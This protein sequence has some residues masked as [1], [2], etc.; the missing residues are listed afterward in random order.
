MKYCLVDTYFLNDRAKTYPLA[1]LADDRLF[2]MTPTDS[3]T[4][5][6]LIDSSLEG[7]DNLSDIIELI[8]EKLGFNP[9]RVYRNFYYIIP[10]IKD[11]DEEF[12]NFLSDLGLLAYDYVDD[13]SGYTY[14]TPTTTESDSAG[15]VNLDAS[16]T[17]GLTGY[18]SGCNWDRGALSLAE[19]DA[20]FFTRNHLNIFQ[21]NLNVWPESFISES[22]F[23]PETIPYA[24]GETQGEDWRRYCRI[25]IEVWFDQ[26]LGKFNCEVQLIG[27]DFN[28]YWYKQTLANVDT[29]DKYNPNDPTPG[30][31][32]PNNKGGQPDGIP[33]TP[34]VTIPTL[35][36]GGMTAAGSIRL[37]RMNSTMIKDLFSYLHANDPGTSIV[38]WFQ[39]PSQAIISLHYLPYELDILGATESIKVLGSDTGVAAY[40]AKERQTIHFGYSDFPRLSDNYLAYSPYT[41]VSIYLPGIG[42]RELN[43]DDIVNKRV[44]VV[45]HCDNVTG[46][47]VA[48][49]AV[50]TKTQTESQASVKYTFSGQVAASWPISQTNWGDTYIAGATLAAGALASGVAAAGTAGAAA[51]GE[52]GAAAGT[53][54]NAGA[55]MTAAN[56]AGGAI[57]KKA[58]NIGSSISSLAKPTISRSGTVSGV[59]S[60]MGI[61]KPYFVIETP[62]Q[63]SYEGFAKVKGYPFG[64]AIKLG[65]LKG[66]AIIEDCHLSGIAGTE[67]EIS[68][69]EGLLKS[70]VIL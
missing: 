46:Q 18:L 69:I 64:Q 23:R 37:Y 16:Y 1:V 70:G 66:Y 22:K 38:K 33:G 49:I 55:N 53:F 7:Y 57:G 2:G 65:S 27:Y 36:P 61:K 42:I 62:H 68:E 12:Y 63:M 11:Q 28:I 17:H 8:D 54:T 60:L 10:D 50:G 58:L 47:F 9:F 34:P 31:S 43:T 41:K 6:E 4:P 25:V 52:G 20:L 26:N 5:V 48:F 32:D 30:G 29:G 35:D 3:S 19:G 24:T 44:W 56:A 59:T 39:N 40:P 13:Y 15:N 67:G 51:A 45:Y 21:Y 14:V